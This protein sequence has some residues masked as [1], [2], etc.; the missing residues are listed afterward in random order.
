MCNTVLNDLYRTCSHQMPHATAANFDAGQQSVLF[1]THSV[2]SSCYTPAQN[3]TMTPVADFRFR[4]ANPAQQSM[5][6]VRAA[7]PGAQHLLMFATGCTSVCDTF[8][9]MAMLYWGQK[10]VSSSFHPHL[11]DQTDRMAIG[12]A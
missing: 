12:S 9:F 4:S 6:L 2:S 7:K 10:V 1:S 3:T 8:E 5:A 11:I